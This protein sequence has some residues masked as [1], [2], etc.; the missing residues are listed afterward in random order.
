MAISLGTTVSGESTVAG[1]S[2]TTATVTWAAGDLVI[3]QYAVDRNDSTNVANLSTVT[4]SGAALTWIK[5]DDFAWDVTGTARH[6]SWVYAAYAASSG[7]GTITFDHGATGNNREVQWA[8]TPV[9]GTD[10]PNGVAQSFVQFVHSAVD[11]IG[12]SLSLT[13]ASES[14]T[15]NRPFLWLGH[16]GSGSGTTFRQFWTEPSDVVGSSAIL[17]T[18]SQWRSDAFETTA[19]ATWVDSG[20]YGGIAFEVKALVAGG[21]AVVLD[22]FGM[23]GFYG[24]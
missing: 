11:S 20:D 3:A 4:D 5:V 14:H 21:A 12:T 24:A 22:P 17:V 19:S 23:S 7:S 15:N 6:R 9:A 13:L 1:T 18:E 2:Y 8:I 16:T 10:A